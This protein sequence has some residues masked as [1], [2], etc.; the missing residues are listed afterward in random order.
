MVPKQGKG[1]K[2]L[3]WNGLGTAD[4]GSTVRATKVALISVTASSTEMPDPSL[5]ISTPKILAAHMAPYSL[6]PVR[7]MSKGRIWSEYQGVASSLSEPVLVMVMLSSWSMVE[8]TEGPRSRTTEDWGR[9][10]SASATKVPRMPL[11]RH[12]TGH[13][14]IG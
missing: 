6:A 4:M 14:L 13:I 5:R 8:L 12:C 10:S 11:V 7:V 9:I 1:R 3:V 2:T